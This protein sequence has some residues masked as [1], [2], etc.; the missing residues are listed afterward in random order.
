VTEGHGSGQGTVEDFL[1]PIP[2]LWDVRNEL[3][4]LA[5]RSE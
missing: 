2:E 1:E 3:T 5:K 4:E